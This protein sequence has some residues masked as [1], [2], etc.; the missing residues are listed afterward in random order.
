MRSANTVWI[1]FVLAAI[2]FQG[3]SAQQTCNALSIV[4]A[5]LDRSRL[6]KATLCDPLE[7]TNQ[8]RWY[9]CLCD[10]ARDTALCYN[11]C[12]NMVAEMAIQQSQVT[13]FCGAASALNP[14]PTSTSSVNSVPT[15]S[16]GGT[17]KVS[18]IPTAEPSDDSEVAKV[19]KEKESSAQ[20]V[21]TGVTLLV[22]L[23]GMALYI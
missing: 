3:T 12:P 15:S 10:N 4:N 17:R 23:A 20:T 9:Q 1:I 11:N 21:V 16:T 19:K 6:L 13:S 5:C 18:D 22:L 2:G 8:A 7:R 14:L